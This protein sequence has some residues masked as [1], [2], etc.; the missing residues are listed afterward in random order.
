MFWVIANLYYEAPPNQLCSIWLNLGREY[1]TIHFRILPAASVFCHVINKHQQ[2][3]ALEAMHAYAIPVPSL[4]H[5][6]F[7]PSFW[8]RLILISAVQRMLFQKWSG[9]FRCFWQSLIWPCLHLV[10]Y[11]LY[12]LWWSLLLIVDFDSDTSTSW[13][14]FFS[15]LDV[16]KGFSLP[17]RGS[18]DHP[19]LLSSV[20]VHAFYVAELSSA[21]FFLRM[22]ETVDVA[23]P[24]VPVISVMDLFCFWSLT[25][26]CF[27]CMESSF[28]CMMGFTA[29][30]S[31]CKIH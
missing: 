21:F 30:A 5:T 7:C 13:R 26:V 29:T 6:F 14:V 3:S 15:W 22:Y 17:W 9:F 11:P 19:P 10:V 25:I 4:L 31:K 1:I 20:D 16:E 12:L 2:P 18:T 27:T 24:N 8:Y 28:D 23:T